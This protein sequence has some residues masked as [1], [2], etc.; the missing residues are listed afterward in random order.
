MVKLETFHFLFVQVCFQM[1][2]LAV[3]SGSVKI[4]GGRGTG[5]PLG[6]LRPG[7]ASHNHQAPTLTLVRLRG[8]MMF[9][10]CRLT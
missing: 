9:H 4:R 1:D 2:Q 7:L 6:L 8:N 10:P 5:L 3:S